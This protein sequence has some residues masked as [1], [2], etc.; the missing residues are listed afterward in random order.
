MKHLYLQYLFFIL[1][2]F[3]IL[4]PSAVY[5]QTFVQKGIID[6]S[7][8]DL[9]N[10]TIYLNGE[11]EFYN[12]KLYTP[13]DFN[14]NKVNKPLMIPVP[15]LWNNLID[16]DSNSGKGFGTYRIKITS[17]KKGYIYA[18]NINR[19]QSAYKIWIND[20]LIKSEGIVG[21]YKAEGKPKWSSSE[22]IFKV[23]KTSADIVLQVSNF[24]HK[25]GGIEKHISFGSVENIL[26]NSWNNLAIDLF[27]LGVF[28]IMAAYHF[29]MFIFRRNDKTNL[30]FALTLI[31]TG[32]FSSIDGEILIMKIFPNLN[33]EILMKSNYISNY[34]RL[35]FFVLFIYFSFKNELSKIFSITISILI[36]GIIIFVLVT[37]ASIYSNTLIIF[38][39][40]T[41][42]SLFYLLYG[43]IKAFFKKKPGTIYSFLGILIL[44]FTATNDILKEYQ[45]IETISLSTFGIF[46]FIIFHSYLISVQN[47]NSYKTIKNITDLLVIQGKIKDALFSAKSYNLESPLKA[48][49][50]AI[51]ADRSLLLIFEENNWVVTNEYLKKDN[52]VKNMKVNV[53]S[54][55]EN[56]FFS[57]KIVKKTIAE[58]KYIF[59]KLNKDIIAKDSTYLKNSNITSLFTYPLIKEG[60]IQSLLYIEN[61]S[62]KPKFEKLSVD[63]LQAIMPQILVFMENYTSYNK[64]NIFNEE[65]ENKVIETATK[66]ETSSRELKILRSEIEKQNISIEEKKQKLEKQ[67]QEINDG[68]RYAKKIQTAFLPNEE[69][70]K[71]VFPES[72][73]LNK[74]KAFL[75]GD[76]YWFSQLNE[77]E[78]IYIAV[79]STG[80]GVSGALMSII[81]HEIINDVILFQKNKSPKIILN[82]IQKEFEERVAEYDQDSGYDLSIVYYNSETSQVIY[83]GAQNPL[84]LVKNDRLL[85]YRAT[86]I[87]IGAKD[88]NEKIKKRYFANS[89]VNVSKGDMLYIFS[90]GYIDQI[91]HETNRK[92]MKSKFIALIK[93]MHKEKTEIQKEKLLDT[94][95][96]WKGEEQQTDDILIIGVRI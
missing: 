90:D 35:L 26:D 19:I 13:T 96:K 44:L 8:I 3:R 20:K 12:K 70:I 93:S 78:S 86:P 9:N 29:G 48:L 49:S 74:P 46:I 64:L 60:S 40:L 33:W 24:H 66:I 4:S 23:N 72:F 67:N 52:T 57:S 10:E 47:A 27:L 39:V 17:L 79:D 89:R 37:P 43:Q 36:S 5:A 7:E 6:L 21:S 55:I 81:G 22:I 82:T 76:F 88:N 53:F 45:I 42:I 73:I 94:F 28:I 75:S 95:S 68:N 56:I 31:F 84:Y 85:E 80:H 50:E 91:G 63:I 83:S 65:L 59:K 15:G 61:Y 2:I 77:T 34:L 30:F 11:W 18:L 16:T 25:K 71:K 51:D 87:S 1:L 32:I 38:L 54:G 58:G 92:F 69:E 14:N 62:E 41:S